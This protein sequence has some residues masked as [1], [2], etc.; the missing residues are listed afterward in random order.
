MRQRNPH[1][2]SALLVAGL[3]V[4]SFIVG[5]SA[6]S[7][8]R[9]RSWEPGQAARHSVSSAT[10]QSLAAAEVAARQDQIGD[11][12]SAHYYRPV[13]AALL[14]DT[15]L[16]HLAVVLDDPYTEYLTPAQLAAFARGDAGT[17]AGIGIHAKLVNHNVVLDRVTAGGPAADAGL[18]VG[19]VLD[20]ADGRLLRVL[21]LEAALKLVRG[22]VGS[23]VTLEV[24]RGDHSVTFVVRRAE[25]AA[26]VVSHQVRRS[27]GQSVGYV[28]VL[29]FSRGV[30][31]AVRAAVKEL[32]SAGVRKV[33]L[34]L[35]HNG[36]GLVDE[37]VALTAVF[38]PAGTPVFIESS[39]HFAKKEY[40]THIAPADTELP[41]VVLVDD[42]SASAAEI[43]TGALRD[44]GRAKV[45]GTK[46]FG[47][48]VI[49]DLVPL[50]G[51]G[52]LKYTMAEYLTP[53]GHKVNR[54]GIVPDVVATTRAD[55]D[56]DPAFEAA[57]H[58][59]R[60]RNS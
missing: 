9:A 50:S 25:V 3:C 17:Y 52:A 20:R 19:D 57:V 39:L 33:V 47:K 4:V 5:G 45:V 55:G 11:L 28:Q 18:R 6:V 14:H 53:S 29:E 44:A 37:A 48:G 10:R 40:R 7:A 38:T 59:S 1:R 43:V 21:D 26:Q 32:K 41:L 31:E 30:G 56:E 34:D 42:Q 27:H 36:G 49:Q 8:L 16:A 13:D 60:P 22:K 2:R 46:T 51:G 15:P 35:R 12:L 58:T 54:L 23:M 24:N